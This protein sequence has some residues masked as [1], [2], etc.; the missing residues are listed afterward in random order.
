MPPLAANELKLGEENEKKDENAKFHI[1]CHF[2]CVESCAALLSKGPYKYKITHPI[3]IFEL[4][5]SSLESK[6]QSKSL[7]SGLNSGFIL[8]H[9]LPFLFSNP[10]SLSWRSPQHRIGLLLFAKDGDDGRR[11]ES[12]GPPPHIS[13]LCL[14]DY[15][16]SSGLPNCFTLRITP[17]L[18]IAAP[19]CSPLPQLPD[20]APPQN[21]TEKCPPL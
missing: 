21:K 6:P 10:E 12:I 2:L 11:S 16:P 18:A 7:S 8:S 14:P 19:F 4:A 15:P 1:F 20:D 9:L 17:D 5:S 13:P 3:D